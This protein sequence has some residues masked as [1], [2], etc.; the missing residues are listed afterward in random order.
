M[1]KSTRTEDYIITDRGGIVENRH[2]VHAAIVDAAGRLLY[3]VGNPTRITLA[4]STAKPAQALAILET[5]AA[6][7]FQFDDA[8]VALMCAS[9]SSE[10]RHVARSRSMLAR[11][12]GLQE[13]DLRCGGHPPLSDEVNRA[14]LRSGFHVGMLAGAAVLGAPFEGYERKA[15]SVDSGG[16]I[17]TKVAGT[18]ERTRK[19]ARIFHAMSD[20]PEM[21]GGEGRFC[22]LFMQAY[23]RG[24]IG[25]LGADGCYGVAIRA[26]EQTAQLSGGG[27]GNAES[28][29][30]GLAVKI[31]DGSIE[32][33]YV[34]VMEILK[35]RGIGNPEVWGK[36]SYFHHL[37]QRN[38]MGVVTGRVTPVFE[39]S[40]NSGVQ[41]F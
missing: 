7:R 38:T 20:Y 1:T 36:L 24:L 2:A 14:W 35:Q 11:V 4:R 17:G 37:E 21:A 16:S 15:A 5:G 25:K 29:V 22:T 34:A 33:L 19:M 13:S 39:I 27:R 26:S 40:E 8:D 18:D 28:Q 23:G 9:H 6:E 12:P 30:L 41:M 10:D 32:I 31:E 3:S